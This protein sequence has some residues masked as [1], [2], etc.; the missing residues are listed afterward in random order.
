MAEK[1]NDSE[2]IDSKVV[3]TL[4]YSTDRPSSSYIKAREGGGGFAFWPIS[5][6]FCPNEDRRVR[7][8][9]GFMLIIALALTE[10]EK[11]LCAYLS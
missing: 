8:L 5:I 11:R 6:V 10:L 3:G 1:I 4:R 9:R 2:K 7:S